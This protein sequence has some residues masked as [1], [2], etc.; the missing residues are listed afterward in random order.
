MSAEVAVVEDSRG[1]ITPLGEFLFALVSASGDSVSDLS[2]RANLSRSFLYL[3]KDDKQVPSIESLVAVLE[4]LGAESVRPGDPG[5]AADLVVRLNGEDLL[6]RLPANSRRAER[7]RS[8][9]RALNS[10]SSLLMGAVSGSL[11]RTSLEHFPAV[12]NTAS[13]APRRG[14]G[15][16]SDKLLGELLDAAAGLDPEQLAL[17]VEHARLLGRGPSRK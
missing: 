1:R 5:E 8:S 15:S 14:R 2:R 17:L 4:A 10:Q 13:G 16:R 7:S 9:M 12:Y 6:I 11:Q 3:L